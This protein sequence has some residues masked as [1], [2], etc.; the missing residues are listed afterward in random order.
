MTPSIEAERLVNGFRA[1]QMV[2]TACRLQLPDLLAAGPKT[3][4]ELAAQTG[5]HPPSLRRM[6]RG[7]SAWGVFAETPDGRFVPTVLSDQFRSDRPGFR[8]DAVMLSEDVYQA[9]GDLLYT[10]QTGSPAFEHVF[11][12]RRFEKLADDPEAAA[13]FN[14][15][16]VE[17]SSRVAAAF[18][19]AYDFDGAR[20]VVDVGG[21]NGGLLVPVLQAQPGMRGI[22]FDLAQRLAGAHERM[23]AAGVADRVTL[24]EGS[25]FEAAPSGGNLYMLKN[26]VHDWD[27]ERSL[28][29][30]RTCRQAMNATAKIVLLERVMPERIV[31]AD[32]ALSALMADLQMMVVLGGRERST[33]EYRN[34]LEEA[35]L[36]VTRVIPTDSGYVAIEAEV[37]G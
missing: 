2:A 5:T 26:I 18:I 37:A 11:G 24:Q 33:D 30:L 35:R 25:F 21:G 14:A 27:D 20:I 8:N 17:R 29:I 4:D 9:W 3:A 22:L 6:L 10:V 31:N 23:V 1:F 15:A 28:V 7:L 12:K 19:A 32:H 34:L 36:R 16:M 13:K